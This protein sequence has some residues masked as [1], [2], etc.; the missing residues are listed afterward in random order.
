MSQGGSSNRSRRDPP[1]DSPISGRSEDGE[2]QAQQTE[3][4]RPDERRVGEEHTAPSPS[5]TSRRSQ[6]RSGK[7][8]SR[9]FSRAVR[10]DMKVEDRAVKSPPL[11]SGD[12]QRRQ[13]GPSAEPR[14]CSLPQAPQG[15]SWMRQTMAIACQQCLS[16]HMFQ[17]KG[18]DRLPGGIQGHI[19]SQ[20]LHLQRRHLRIRRL[21]VF[22]A[23][24][25]G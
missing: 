15:T 13:T 4:G 10:R 23:R 21:D 3:R 2:E 16:P 25:W 20:Q 5:S 24:T 12:L 7:E 6:R 9:A 19:V 1:P 14:R 18:A 17:G 11:S 22:P 8:A